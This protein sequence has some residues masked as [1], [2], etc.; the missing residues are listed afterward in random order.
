MLWDV[1]AARE[2]RRGRRIQILVLE[3]ADRAVYFKHS[4]RDITVGCDA[5][6]AQS[7]L[8]F[9]HADVFF[10]HMGQDQLPVVNEQAGL[11]LNELAKAT[12]AAG[13]FGDEIVHQQQRQRC[14]NSASER[15]VGAGHG[16]LHR[17]A[18]KQQEGQIERSH[19][20]NFAFAAEANPD[21]DNQVDGEGAKKNFAENMDVGRKHRTVAVAE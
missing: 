16:V 1:L 4:Q 20:A 21:Q 10:R 5:M 8:Q 11:A 12:I 14:H 9:I 19:L 6:L 2:M 17:I 7:S 18:K 3:Q 13:E 15:S